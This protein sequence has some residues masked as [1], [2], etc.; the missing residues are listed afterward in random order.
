MKEKIIP[1]HLLPT[2]S[3]GRVK[4]L[5]SLDGMRRR[6]LD[7]GFING[8]VVES[9][10]RSPFGIYCYQIRGLSLPSVRRSVVFLWKEYD[11]VRRDLKFDGS[12]IYQSTGPASL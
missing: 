11:S 7:L 3:S 4:E 8:T 10:R 12:Y 9:L 5:R 2:G 1:L 6:L